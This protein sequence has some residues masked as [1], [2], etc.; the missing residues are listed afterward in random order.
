VFTARDLE[1]LSAMANQAAIAI[2]NSQLFGELQDLFLNTVTPWPRRSTPRTAI[3]PA[4]A[5]A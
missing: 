3:P 5:T 4:T 1:V 2:R